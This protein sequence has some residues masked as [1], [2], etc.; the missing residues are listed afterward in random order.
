MSDNADVIRGVYAGFASGDVASIFAKFA[1]D[2]AWTEAE[3]FPYAG[4]YVG[5]DA[6]LKGVFMKLGGEWKGFKAAPE[7]YVAQGDTVCV[8]G[9]YSGTYRATGKAMSAPFVHVWKLKDGRI[10]RLIQH[11]DTAVVA[12]ALG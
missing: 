4:T 2:I 8:I 1:P 6:I 7:E 11:T 9:T 5:A 12:R 3:G 10:V